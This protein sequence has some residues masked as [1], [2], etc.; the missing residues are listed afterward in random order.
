MGFA[1]NNLTLLRNEAIDLS[2]SIDKVTKVVTERLRRF[3]SLDIDFTTK[4]CNI[5]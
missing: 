3:L 4:R 1:L 2:I 5:R